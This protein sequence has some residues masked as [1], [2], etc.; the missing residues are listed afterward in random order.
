MTLAA[1][2]SDYSWGASLLEDGLAAFRV[3]A[4]SAT[5]VRVVIDGGEH[6]LE[7]LGD[8]FYCGTAP[9][10]AGS[11]YGFRL[12]D[13]ERVLPDPA[14]RFQPDGVDGLSEVVD[15]R[16]FKWTDQDWRGHP[17]DRHV[18]YELH[19]GTF[20][21][22]GTWR[23]ALNE[24][25]A[26][27]RLGVTTLQVMPVNTFGGHFG[28]GYDG[29]FW[30]APHPAYGRP[31]D[32]RAFVDTAHH[33]GLAVVLDV[34]YNHVGP[35]GSV[36]RA[37]APDYFAQGAPSEWGEALNY[38]GPQSG[39]VRRFVV[40]NAAYWMREFH[41]DGLRLDATQQIRDSSPVHVITEATCAARDAACHARPVVIAE[42]EPQD[43]QLLQSPHLHGCGL[44]I[45]YNDDFHHS[46]RVRLTGWRDAYYSDYAGTAQE[47]VS[48][49]RH[50]FLFQGQFYAWQ[51][52]RR[53]TSSI[54]LDPWR[55]L[56][57]LE[58]H[59]QVANSD[60]AGRRL[61][62]LT[63][64]AQLRAMT[65]LLLLGPWTPAL[66]QG[67][68]FGSSRPWLYFADHPGQLGLDVHEG[69]ETFMQQFRRVR[70]SHSQEN[71][72]P[73][74][75]PRAFEQ[76]QLQRPAGGVEQSPMWRLHHDLLTLRRRW[77]GGARPPTVDA[78][79]PSADLFLLHAWLEGDEYLLAV[80]LGADLDLARLSDPLV[81]PAS[82]DRR[83]RLAW[84]SEAPAYGGSGG[85]VPGEFQWVA[86]GHAATV[87]HASERGEDRR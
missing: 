55:L 61:H 25:P 39:P 33:L 84:S 48:C 63:S 41:F 82:Q 45:L 13:D 74:N 34:V 80:N 4:P 49:V 8:G 2:P 75:D 52:Q 56:C 14:S 66:F 69:R 86:A 71:V 42:N 51:Q 19:C 38:D 3:W 73:P 46:T 30:Y 10:A 18:V 29:V 7:L 35:R 81:A 31:D 68:E 85:P 65:A 50:G 12:G 44:D 20:T 15:S 16:G 79:A 37:F 70:A 27:A 58:N 59:D 60:R 62:V 72:L 40:D 6:D 1:S 23:A 54:G 76:C 67:Q 26:L 87:L 28:W 53:G 47:W 36:L 9:A 21:S 78:S 5:R 43:V 57:C 17:V 64:P 11:R 83:W 24:L 22:D 32:L 77:Y